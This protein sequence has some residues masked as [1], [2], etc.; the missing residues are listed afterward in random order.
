MAVCCA[1]AEEIEHD[2]REAL[3]GSLGSYLAGFLITGLRGVERGLKQAS[4][5]SLVM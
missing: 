5:M 2:E 1:I 4:I 3:S